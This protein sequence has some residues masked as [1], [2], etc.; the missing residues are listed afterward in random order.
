MVNRAWLHSWKDGNGEVVLRNRLVKEAR[1]DFFILQRRFVRGDSVGNVV[2]SQEEEKRIT[3]ENN[4]RVLI[5]APS[6]KKTTQSEHYT[7]MSYMHVI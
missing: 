7:C 5:M 2:V 3:T 6:K 1:H 4:M